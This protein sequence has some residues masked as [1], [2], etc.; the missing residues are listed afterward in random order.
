[1]LKWST[2]FIFIFTLTVSP[3]FADCDCSDAVGDKFDEASD[4]IPDHFDPVHEALGKVKDAAE[5]AKEAQEQETKELEAM[6]RRERL[7]VREEAAQTAYATKLLV[8]DSKEYD[9]V[10]ARAQQVVEMLHIGNLRYMTRS[11]SRTEHEINQFL[12][13]ASEY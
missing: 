10:Q 11:Y 13:E 6:V 9:I 8:G 2:I 12:D 3:V 5:N 1:M 4:N 7:L